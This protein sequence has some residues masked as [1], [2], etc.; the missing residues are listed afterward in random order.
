MHA[1]A[2][3]GEGMGHSDKLNVLQRTLRKNNITAE[4]TAEHVL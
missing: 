3:R 1:I 2:Q 4:S